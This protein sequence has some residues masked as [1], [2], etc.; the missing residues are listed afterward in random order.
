MAVARK[1][2]MV[3]VI[4]GEIGLRVEIGSA[5]PAGL[6][7]GLVHMHLVVRVRQTD[8]GREA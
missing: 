7:R 4:D 8:G 3:A 6:L 5:A 2:Q 1:Q